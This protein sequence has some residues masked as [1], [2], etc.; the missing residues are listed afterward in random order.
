MKVYQKRIKNATGLFGV[1]RNRFKFCLQI[2]TDIDPREALDFRTMRLGV[3][4][5]Q[6]TKTV[7]TISGSLGT[8]RIK[9]QYGVVTV[10]F[11]NKK[12]RDIIVGLLPR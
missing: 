8:Y 7:V 10:L 2:F 12:L 9:S 11:H 4:E 3:Q 1:Q 6:F 5:S